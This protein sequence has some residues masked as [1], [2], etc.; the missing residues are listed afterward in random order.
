M[1]L[2]GMEWLVD[3]FG[4]PANVLQDRRTM[5]AL[6]NTVVREMRLHPM[7]DPVWHQFPTTKGMTGFWMLLESHMTIH[8]FPE[9]ES[10][11]FNLFCCSPRT[12]ID[13]QS[14]FS[15]MIQATSVSIRECPREYSGNR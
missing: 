3:I 5:S 7:G 12:G 6:F 11:C 1:A 8:T 9:F 2:N 10:A 13:W 4:C 15:R 14:M